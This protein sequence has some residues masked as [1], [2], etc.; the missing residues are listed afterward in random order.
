M[1]WNDLSFYS[2]LVRLKGYCDVCRRNYVVSFYSILVRLKADGAD[3]PK[4]IAL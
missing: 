2:I 1:K 3:M 4:S